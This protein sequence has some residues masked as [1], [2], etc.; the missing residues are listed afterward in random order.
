[1]VQRN[2]AEALAMLPQRV[3]VGGS[4]HPRFLPVEGG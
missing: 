3:A 1:M 2:A 4:P